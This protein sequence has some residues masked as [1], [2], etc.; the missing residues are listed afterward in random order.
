MIASVMGILIILA[1]IL[2]CFE[3]VPV[4][5]SR[6]VQPRDVKGRYTR[7]PLQIIRVQRPRFRKLDERTWVRV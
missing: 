1:L 7:L 2:S 4:R 3:V 6:K 5:K